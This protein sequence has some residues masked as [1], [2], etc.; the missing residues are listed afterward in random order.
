MPKSGWQR[1]SRQII[2]HLRSRAEPRDGQRESC[3]S[4]QA[5]E[6]CRTYSFEQVALGRR[7]QNHRR[8]FGWHESEKSQA[9]DENRDSKF[10]HMVQ[11]TGEVPILLELRF[12]NLQEAQRS[13]SFR[14][15]SGARLCTIDRWTTSRRL[16]CRLAWRG[17]KSGSGWGRS[18]CAT[19]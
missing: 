15:L 17:G 5:S 18:R 12:I 14:Q 16:A 8:Q 3:G 7:V 2:L 11:I 9:S 10:W 4:A 1:P 13:S 6:I 19:R